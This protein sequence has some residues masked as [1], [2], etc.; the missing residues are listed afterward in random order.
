MCITREQLQQEFQKGIAELNEIRGELTSVGNMARPLQPQ[1]AAPSPSSAPM[2]AAAV[3]G[4][5]GMY[6]HQQQLMN[7]TTGEQFM[8]LVFRVRRE[9]DWGRVVCSSAGGRTLEPL[10]RVGELCS[11]GR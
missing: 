4:A 3:G 9:A 6:Q 8:L 2:E 11:A 7:R 1:G 5:A 10:T